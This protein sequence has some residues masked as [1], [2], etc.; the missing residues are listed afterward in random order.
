MLTQDV[1]KEFYFVK[2]YP[3]TRRAANVDPLVGW[4]WTGSVRDIF[5]IAINVRNNRKKKAYS[6]ANAKNNNGWLFCTASWRIV[7]SARSFP[8]LESCVR[9]MKQCYLSDTSMFPIANWKETVIVT[10]FSHTLIYWH[11]LSTHL[12]PYREVKGSRVGGIVE[13]FEKNKY[14]LA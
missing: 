5:V 14:W 9:A 10:S 6:N 13:C 2:T 4:P 7:A 11:T 8:C 3:S 12:K 1:L